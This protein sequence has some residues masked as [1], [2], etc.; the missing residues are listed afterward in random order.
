MIENNKNKSKK[1]RRREGLA[2][3]SNGC[4][5]GTIRRRRSST[6]CV[7]TEDAQIIIETPLSPTALIEVPIT[8]LDDQPHLFLS[9]NTSLE[10]IMRSKSFQHY[11][12]SSRCF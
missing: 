1:R 3:K 6:R 9:L 10:K 2:E 12:I 5:K 11:E 7:M 4:Q 8:M